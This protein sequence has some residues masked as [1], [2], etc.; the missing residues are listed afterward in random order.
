MSKIQNRLAVKPKNYS[1]TIIMQKSFNQ[2][3]QFFK[4]YVK[5]TWLKSPMIN[6]ALP[7]SNHFHPIIIKVTFNF[8]KFVSVYNKPAHF[9][10]S[11]L[12]YS[13]LEF[14][15]LNEH[16]HFLPAPPNNYYSNFWLSWNFIN[17]PKISLFHQFLLVIQ[18]ILVSWDESCYKLI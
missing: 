15:D 12:R 4:S 1:I 2:S 3:A 17:I 13:I 5:T 10:H 11:F 7:I 16:A 8:H 6:K 14:Q 9:I 18:P